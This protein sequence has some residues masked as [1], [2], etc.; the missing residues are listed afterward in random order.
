MVITSSDMSSLFMSKSDI[1][2]LTYEMAP[3]GL[4]WMRIFSRQVSIT[5]RTIRQLSRLTVSMP[6]VS[7]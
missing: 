2:F 4:R 5:C 7:M 1:V 6:L 3:L